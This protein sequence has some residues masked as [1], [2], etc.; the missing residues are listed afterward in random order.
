M[1]GFYIYT[2]WVGAKILADKR[3]NE[4]THR[5]YDIGSLLSTL[6][7]ILMGMMMVMSL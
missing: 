1:F 4:S 2:F 3:I 7:A 5:T 6:M